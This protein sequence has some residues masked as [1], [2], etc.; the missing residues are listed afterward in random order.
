MKTINSTQLIKETE[1]KQILNK[2]INKINIEK[3]NIIIKP[4]HKSYML[5]GT[6]S[7]Y[8][9]RREIL[10]KT[11]DFPLKDELICE[12]SIEILKKQ[13][14]LSLISHFDI[15]KSIK[16]YKNK[17][18]FDNLYESILNMARLDSYYR[19]GFFDEIF[20]FPNKQELTQDLTN[21]KDNFTNN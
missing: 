19:R 21:I 1:I 9:I 5:M 8:M 10:I 13:D 14:K 4:K 15:E 2:F 3:F 11:K 6:A 17:N 18:N 12:K 7:D 16:N 20:G